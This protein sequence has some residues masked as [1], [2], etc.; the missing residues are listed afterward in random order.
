MS[1]PS[2]NRSPALKINVFHN[3]FTVPQTVQTSAGLEHKK[4][5][6]INKGI[7]HN[8]ADADPSA[9]KFWPVEL[10]VCQCSYS[11]MILVSFNF[12]FNIPIRFPIRMSTF[13]SFK[14][15]LRKKFFASK[16]E[17]LLCFPIPLTCSTPISTTPSN[18][19]I[20]F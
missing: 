3:E 4:I 19:D 9:H 12:F 7:V 17:T 11:I 2:I 20:Q 15:N 6:P 13:V 10:S 1:T 16:F 5:L 14:L 8:F 18:I